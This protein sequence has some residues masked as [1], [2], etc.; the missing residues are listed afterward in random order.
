MKSF[1][2][3]SDLHISAKPLSGMDDFN[4]SDDKISNYIKKKIDEKQKIVLLGDVFECWEPSLE[5]I[6]KFKSDW[7]N[8]MGK[9]IIDTIKNNYPIFTKLINEN[10]KITYISGN[11]DS[12]CYDLK[13][14]N[15]VKQ[16]NVENI[17]GCNIYFA[18]GHQADIYNSSYSG[19]G[20]CIVCCFCSVE[21]LIDKNADHNADKLV[22]TLGLDKGDIIYE[23]HACLLADKNNYD[24][25]IYGHTHRPYIKILKTLAGKK[26]MYINT[27]RVSDGNITILQ[28]N[29]NNTEIVFEL[30]H[31][32]SI[33]DDGDVIYKALHEKDRSHTIVFSR[34]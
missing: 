15:N 6:P 7:H 5:N 25:V 9:N 3:I 11:H 4:I 1:T 30:V 16:Y 19:V 26:I 27:G 12:C 17:N 29:A 2:V 10:D 28:I 31:K 18:H 23:E 8:E 13:L 22:L 20:K 21:Q 32:K 33:E 24:V 34:E 14:F